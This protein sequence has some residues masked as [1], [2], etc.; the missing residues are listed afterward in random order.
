[1]TNPKEPTLN[2]K[3]I[4]AYKNGDFALAEELERQWKYDEPTKNRI[5]DLQRGFVYDDDFERNYESERN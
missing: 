4:N 3:L 1:M 2:E 5:Y